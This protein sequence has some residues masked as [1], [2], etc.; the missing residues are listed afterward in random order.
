M[1]ACQAKGL[2]AAFSEKE[3]SAGNDLVA[4]EAQRIQ[5]SGIIINVLDDHSLRVVKF[6][7]RKPFNMLKKMDA[8]YES[9]TIA[10]NISKMVEFVSVRNTPPRNDIANTSNVWLPFLRNLSACIPVWRSL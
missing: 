4:F 5:I 8:R 10:S 1:A 2:T 9:K 3:I 7:K 6:V